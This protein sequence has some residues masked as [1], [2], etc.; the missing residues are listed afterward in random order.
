[1]IFVYGNITDLSITNIFMICLFINLLSSRIQS[2]SNYRLI[3]SL[4]AK[5]TITGSVKKKAKNDLFMANFRLY[6]NNLIK[7]EFYL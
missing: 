6:L 3:K 5:E 4:M 2:V 7:I 1:M